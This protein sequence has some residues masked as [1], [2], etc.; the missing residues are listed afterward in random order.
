MWSCESYMSNPN[1]QKTHVGSNIK[2]FAIKT[3]IMIPTNNISSYTGTGLHFLS[4]N[5]MNY[6]AWTWI[7]LDIQD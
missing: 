4:S 1:Q 5:V 3:K 2:S 6:D 7:W